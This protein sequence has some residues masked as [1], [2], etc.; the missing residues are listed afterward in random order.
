PGEVQRELNR[1]A[2][3]DQAGGDVGQP[4][5]RVAHDLQHGGFFA[6][7]ARLV[8]GETAVPQRVIHVDQCL[9]ILLPRRSIDLHAT[10]EIARD[11]R[12]RVAVVGEVE[13][14]QRE[15]F[16]EAARAHLYRN[17]AVADAK[18]LRIAK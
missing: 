2:E 14:R 5:T 10:G 17:L 7:V 11:L 8:E 18:R 15:G 12:A 16:V 13:V 4:A 9:A 1:Q 6:A 3:E